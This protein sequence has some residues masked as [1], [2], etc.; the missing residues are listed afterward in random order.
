M[1]KT[2]KS[3]K[4]MAAK[5]KAPVSR[6]P[7][8]PT[9]FTTFRKLMAKAWRHAGAPPPLVREASD[10]EYEGEGSVNALYDSWV[11]WRF[12]YDDIQS[13]KDTHND[14]RRELVSTLAYYAHDAS[15]ESYR[16]YT[17]LWNY[18]PGYRP[19][20]FKSEA[21]KNAFPKK[22]QKHILEMFGYKKNKSSR[23]K[24]W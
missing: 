23:L 22:V 1:M 21:E 24:S 3:K 4:K 12:E 7:S 9:K 18:E 6:A 16:E 2:N 10:L 8:I 15:I 5:K 20:M 17:N 14:I 19:T 13:V 11:D